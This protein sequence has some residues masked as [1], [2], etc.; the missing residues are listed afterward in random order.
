MAK[1]PFTYRELRKSWQE[2]IQFSIAEPRK[3]PHRLL[4]FY[5][6]E[7]GLKAVYLKQQSKDVIDSSIAGVFLHDINKMC[8][9]MRMGQEYQLPSNLKLGSYKINNQ[10]IPRGCGPGE[11][12]QVWRY[13][14]SLEGDSDNL[15]LEKSLAKINDW[16]TKELS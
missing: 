10:P 7:C 13:G 6:V 2:S 14:G 4:L 16:V 8:L 1:I 12:N 15:I 5:A 11:L 9:T 3:N